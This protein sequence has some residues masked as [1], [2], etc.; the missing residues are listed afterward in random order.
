MIRW[1]NRHLHR[2]IEEA[3]K[4]ARKALGDLAGAHVRI[5]ELESKVDT[6]AKQ[7]A[8]LWQKQE[9]KS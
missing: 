4:D 6:Q 3:R 2:A 8:H 7:I 1:L 9:P 5:R